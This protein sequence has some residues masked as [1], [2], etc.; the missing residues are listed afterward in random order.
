MQSNLPGYILIAFLLS[1]SFYTVH[2]FEEFII[3]QK[4][5]LQKLC[6]DGCSQSTVN[7]MV[8]VYL[9]CFFLFFFLLF[10]VLKLVFNDLHVHAH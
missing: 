1:N 9:F 2:S 8:V 5:L 3:T 7:K 4:A 6:E 10:L